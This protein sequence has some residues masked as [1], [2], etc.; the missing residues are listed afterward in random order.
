MCRLIKKIQ[1]KKDEFYE[2]YRRSILGFCL[3]FHRL[4]DV[5]RRDTVD[6]GGVCPSLMLQGVV[7]G[8]VGDATHVEECVFLSEAACCG[9]REKRRVRGMV[10]HPSGSMF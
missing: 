1:D 8:W 6:A 2:S 3:I 5:V 10:V 4:Q 7:G 9:M